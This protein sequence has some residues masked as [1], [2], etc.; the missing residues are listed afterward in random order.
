MFYTGSERTRWKSNLYFKVFFSATQSL[1]LKEL[2]NCL[3]PFRQVFSDVRKKA[4]IENQCADEP[5]KEDIFRI[6]RRQV[7]LRMSDN[8]DES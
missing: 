2:R 7:R 5:C 8:Q 1:S 6:K 3:A 4:T